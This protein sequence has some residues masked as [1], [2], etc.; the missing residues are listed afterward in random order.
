[1]VFIA[2]QTKG[3]EGGGGGGGVLQAKT[4]QLDQKPSPG[5]ESKQ[6]GKITNRNKK[7]EERE[8]A[9]FAYRKQKAITHGFH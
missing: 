3:R 4:A 8:C 6:T 5:D 2:C 7:E 9:A 1:M